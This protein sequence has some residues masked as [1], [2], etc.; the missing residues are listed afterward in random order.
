[1]P[2]EVYPQQFIHVF[3][4]ELS[5]ASMFQGPL[6]VLSLRL[7]TALEIC[8][9]VCRHGHVNSVGIATHFRLEWKLR[10]SCAQFRDNCI[11]RTY[12]LVS[13]LNIEFL[14]EVLTFI[15]REDA[16][17]ERCVEFVSLCSNRWPKIEVTARWK[18]VFQRCLFTE[19]SCSGNTLL[20]LR[21]AATGLCRQPIVPW[22]LVMTATLSSRRRWG[23]LASEQPLNAVNLTWTCR[24]ASSRLR[25]CRW[26]AWRKVPRLTWHKPSA[27]R[28]AW[29]GVCR[30][31]PAGRGSDVWCSPLAWSAPDPGNTR[32]AVGRGDLAILE[33]KQTTRY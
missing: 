13:R 23:E 10:I 29:G 4:F 14:G 22:L 5:T 9:S 28:V 21:C 17:Y 32:L 19:I 20:S 27:G 25:Q 16:S 6:Q 3:V 33:R 31:E 1:M 30:S 12:Q 8:I 26:F 18:I 11:E 2:A 24:R 15:E 7:D